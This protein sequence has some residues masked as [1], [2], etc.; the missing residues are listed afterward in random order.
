MDE[1]MRL[2]GAHE[3]KELLGVSRQRVYQLAA[4]ADFPKPVAALAQGKV[5]LLGDIE[6]WLAGRR[7]FGKGRGKSFEEEVRD[8]SG[9]YLKAG[10]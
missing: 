1:S 4:K 3:V 2:A 9:D 10:A 7:I 8:L 6:R 5:W